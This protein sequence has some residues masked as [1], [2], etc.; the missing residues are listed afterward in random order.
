MVFIVE[1]K[2]IQPS[3]KLMF[4]DDDAHTYTNKPYSVYKCNYDGSR[5]A[6][7]VNKTDSLTNNMFFEHV[8]LK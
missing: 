2:M 1:H 7:F 4:I 6:V 5:K 3:R 8:H